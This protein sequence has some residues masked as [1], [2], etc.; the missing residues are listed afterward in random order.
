MGFLLERVAYKNILDIERLEIP[1]GK[2][3]CITGE[4]GSG[5]TTLLRLLNN[6]ISA[7]RGVVFYK[8]DNVDRIDPVALRRR[9]VMLPQNPVMFPGTV[10]DN[11][12]MSLELAGKAPK[13]ENAFTNILERVRLRKGLREDAA[14]FSGGEKQRL[15]LARVLVL[16]PETLLLDEPS[17]ALDE[18]TE[19]EVVTNVVD[20]A[21]KE[22]RTLV[23]V[24]HSLEMARRFAKMLVTVRGGNVS[25]VKREAG[26]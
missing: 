26:R 1:Q 4:S 8:G 22:G 10:A 14:D 6:L 20:C 18:K 17:S 16:E 19:E 9:V 2:V 11:L 5:K 7:E 12:G 24:L 23:M 3:T 13:P 15:A 25:V 21:R